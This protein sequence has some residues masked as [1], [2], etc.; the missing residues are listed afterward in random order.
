MANV[1]I[2]VVFLE[3]KQHKLSIA[4][5]VWARAKVPKVLEVIC[6]LYVAIYNALF[7]LKA[8]LYPKAFFE[9]YSFQFQAIP[10]FV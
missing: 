8:I 9:Q 3:F 6:H 7:F 5:Q 2:A 4:N 1:A 10:Q